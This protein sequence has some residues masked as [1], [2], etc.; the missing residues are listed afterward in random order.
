MEE[1][2]T[3]LS[4]YP[5][6]VKVIAY[7]VIFNGVVLGLIKTL[8]VIKDKTHTDIDDKAYIV[9]D[10]IQKFLGALIAY[11]KKEPQ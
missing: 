10:K 6:F 3:Y 4:Q 1:L 9:L 2:I 5:Q 7:V 11:R 8:E